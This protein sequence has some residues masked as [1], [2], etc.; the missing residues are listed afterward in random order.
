MTKR[1]D[2]TRGG[3]RDYLGANLKAQRMQGPGAKMGTYDPFAGLRPVIIDPP[4][5]WQGAEGGTATFTVSAVSGDGTSLSYQWQA[6]NGDSWV[7]ISNGGDISGAT[8]DTLT[9]ENVQYAQWNGKQVRCAV[10]NASTTT[11]SSAARV[12]ISSAVFYIQTEAG[13]RVVDEPAT[14]NVVDERSS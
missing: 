12:L 2:R 5:N 4:L 7:D 8:T 10:T 1:S 6:L 11:Y 13:D 3:Q 9:I 14:S